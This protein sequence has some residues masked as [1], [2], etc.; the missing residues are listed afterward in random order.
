MEK[1][2][3]N[4][5]GLVITDGVGYRNFILSKFLME[6]SAEFDEVIIYS[7]LPAE[8]FDINAYNNIRVRELPVFI[9]P[10]ITWFLRKTKEVAHLRLHNN[11]FGINDN[12]LAN[13]SSGKS[14]RAIATR[15]IYRITK[16]FHSENFIRYIEKKQISSISKHSVTQ[17]CL[18][19]LM[20]DQPN[21][22]FFTHQRP[23]YVVP[24]VAAAKRLKIN[25]ISFIFSWDNLSSKGRMAADFGSYL[26]WS[27][28]MK[29]DMN[30]FYPTTVN[31]KVAVVGTPQFEPYVMEEYEMSREVF[32]NLFDLSVDKKVICYSCGDISTS[33][34]DEF[35]IESIA[36]A[37]SQDKIHDRVN[38]IVRTSPAEE[39]DR[40]EK[41]KEK[42]PFIKWNFPKWT[43]SRS[44]HPEAWSQR[45]P[46]RKDIEELRALL[47]YSDLG[48]NMCSTMSLD[49]MIFGKPVINPVFGNENSGLYNDQRFLQFE[50]YKNVVESGAVIV[51][52]NDDELINEINFCLN[53]PEIRTA[54]QSHLLGMQIGEPLEGTSQ[55]IVRELLELA[56]N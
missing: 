27:E 30:Y 53:N 39:P 5:L 1:K 8:I 28:L 43:I 26:V 4:T 33:Q 10:F 6:A 35:Y 46:D 50:H 38:F 16:R 14:N 24:V 42:F 36:T 32:F 25:T 54:E 18:K 15:F 23:P 52:K 2:A 9:E 11:F 47:K 3:T 56:R 21:L 45:V 7:G 51:V 20:E 40:F 12:Y 29:K 22:L 44:N 41:L 34:N 19:F 49:F 48:I 17:S 31:R 13:R 37:L 55:R